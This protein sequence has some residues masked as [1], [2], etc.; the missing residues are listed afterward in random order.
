MINYVD[1]VGKISSIY[2][3]TLINCNWWSN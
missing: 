3:N 1:F 2:K